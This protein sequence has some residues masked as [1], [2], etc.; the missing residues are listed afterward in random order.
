MNTN[1]SYLKYS[2]KI[3]SGMVDQLESVSPVSFGMNMWLLNGVKYRRPE[4]RA[5]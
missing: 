4:A 2:L 5:T 3:I 1:F